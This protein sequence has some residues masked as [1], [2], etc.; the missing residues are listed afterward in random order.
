MT[1]YPVR[2]IRGRRLLRKRK[3]LALIKSTNSKNKKKSPKSPGVKKS[4][5]L[6][7]RSENTSTG[8][9]EKKK[10]KRHDPPLFREP[11]GEDIQ[12]KIAERA[13]EL[14]E[15]R[16][17]AHGDDWEDWLNAENEFFGENRRF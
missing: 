9:G 16:G 11:L 6:N 4:A 12:A 2:A 13:H 3:A 17:R 15:Q 14:F 7:L 5:N 8:L 1:L 10:R